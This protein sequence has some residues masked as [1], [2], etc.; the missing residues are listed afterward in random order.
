MNFTPHT[1]TDI[2]LTVYTELDKMKAPAE[3]AE[4]RNSL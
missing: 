4:L 1:L 3:P 2:I